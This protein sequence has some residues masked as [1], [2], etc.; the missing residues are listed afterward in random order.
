MF[1]LRRANRWRWRRP[2][3]LCR[4][5]NETVQVP[6]DHGRRDING[7][8]LPSLPAAREGSSG[9]RR[10]GLADLPAVGIA[11]RERG[12]F[13]NWVACSLAFWLLLLTSC[14]SP[15]PRQPST[16]T[17]YVGPTSLNL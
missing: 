3:P 17:A 5:I 12:R 16:G 4:R 1:S 13:G 2:I 11:A 6:R 9:V 7:I 15:P 14:S 10:L 8:L